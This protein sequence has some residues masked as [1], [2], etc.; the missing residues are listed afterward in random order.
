M[1]HVVPIDSSEKQ[2]TTTQVMPIDISEGSE[3]V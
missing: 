2:K 3:F 1:T